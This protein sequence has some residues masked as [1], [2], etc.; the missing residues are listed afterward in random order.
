MDNEEL[1]CHEEDDKKGRNELSFLVQE[2]GLKGFQ[3]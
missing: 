3:I 2:V 1:E